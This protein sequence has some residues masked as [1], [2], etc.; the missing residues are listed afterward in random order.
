L[1]Q[2]T[3][4]FTIDKNASNDELQEQLSKVLYSN[5]AKMK[6]IKEY[7]STVDVLQ[8]E[9]YDLKKKLKAEKLRYA[10]NITQRSTAVKIT[11]STVNN[12]MRTNEKCTYF[13][14]KP[15]TLNVRKEPNKYSKKVHTLKRNDKLCVIS[16]KSSWSYIKDKGW[17]NSNYLTKYAPSKKKKKTVTKKKDRSV[18]HCSAKSDRASGWVE[19]VGKQNA[20]NGA[21]RQCNIRKV[22]N[23]TCKINNCYKIR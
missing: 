8:N 20:M 17:V 10:Q 5:K 12:T 15:K 6:T 14:V 1:T 4:A 22:T 13:Y 18:W 3:I 19:R 2:E 21:I 7:K 23:S 9:N 16:K 11:K